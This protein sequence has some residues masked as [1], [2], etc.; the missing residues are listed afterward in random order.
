VDIEII[1]NMPLYI[2]VGFSLLVTGDTCFQYDDSMHCTVDITWGLTHKSG[3]PKTF[4]MKLALPPLLVAILY[5]TWFS[6]FN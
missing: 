6:A 3:V 2:A 5:N 4:Q 1:V